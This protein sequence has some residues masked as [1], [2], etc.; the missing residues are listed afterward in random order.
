ML[1]LTDPG[2]FVVPIPPTLVAVTAGVGSWP[3]TRTEL[4]AAN[5]ALTQADYLIMGYI[6]NGPGTYSAF[7]LYKG[8]SNGTIIHEEAVGAQAAAHSGLPLPILVA[9]GT[10]IST[11]AI[12]ASGSGACTMA[13]ICASRIAL[14][15]SEA[16]VTGT[17]IGTVAPA[18]GVVTDLVTVP[19]GRFAGGVSVEI[20]NQGA[21]DVLVRVAVSPLGATY[22]DTHDIM[23]GATIKAGTSLSVP[24]P[25][26][27]QA[28]DKIRVWTNGNTLTSTP[29]GKVLTNATSVVFSITAVTRS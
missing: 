20:N 15:D 26:V 11:D 6:F 4:I 8:A 28:T 19:A 12:V 5:Q 23:T 27:L 17:L 18:A 22:A 24:V 9:G 14:G 21:A 29:G 1:V 7:R 16:I 2:G 3:G 13:L 25:F 10:R